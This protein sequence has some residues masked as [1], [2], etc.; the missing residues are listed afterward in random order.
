[1]SS[2]KAML[3]AVVCLRMPILKS[4]NNKPPR[5]ATKTKCKNENERRKKINKTN[6][7]FST[8]GNQRY[9]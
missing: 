9:F 2:C 6:D 4:N 8:I 5:I 3:I 1:M 7:F